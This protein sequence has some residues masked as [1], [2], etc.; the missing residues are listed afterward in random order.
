MRIGSPVPELQDAAL[1]VHEAC[2]QNG[3]RLRVE[4]RPRKDARMVE[5]D[6]AWRLFDCDDY[7]CQDKDFKRILEWADLDLKFDLFASSKNT[8]FPKFAARLAEWGHD[9]W[10]NAFA[11]DWSTLGEVWACPPPGLVEPVLRQFVAQKA[12]GILLIPRWKTSKYWPILAPEGKHFAKFVRRFL[13][14]TL[15]MKVGKD[16]LSDTF[17]KKSPFLVL[18]VN[19]TVADPWSEDL[20]F[21][22]CPERGCEK[23]ERE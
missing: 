19:G 12:V 8:K 16:V 18:R 23:C 10:V 17:R 7:T 3:V 13:E 9:E 14:L 15:V 20:N 5:A 22:N 2:R 11:L 21:L 4:W 1:A 6:S